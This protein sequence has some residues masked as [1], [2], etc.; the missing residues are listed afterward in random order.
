MRWHAAAALALVAM[1]ALAATRT[2]TPAAA[3][4]NRLTP[5]AAVLATAKPLRYT[6][7]GNRDGSRRFVFDGGLDD[8]RLFDAAKA[9]VPYLLL[10]TP[11]AEERWIGGEILWVTPTKASSGFELDLG[12]I[13]TIDR[14]RIDGIHAPFLKRARVEGSGDRAHWTL[15]AADTTL[16]DLPD[17]QLKNHD[18]TFPAGAHRYVRVT[19]DDR[20][21][22]RVIGMGDVRARV[23]T[24][25]I[26]AEGPRLN[27][28]FHARGSE[29]GKSRYRIVLPG[30]HLPIAAVQ[31]QVANGN[32]FR[33]ASISEGRLTNGAIEQ[34][35]LGNAKL[36]RAERDGAVAEQLAIPIEFPTGA[37]LELLVDDANNPPLQITGIV[38]Q[39]APL[40]S[41]YFESRDGAPLTA[42]Y[43]DDKR[44]APQYD[45]EASRHAAEKSVAPEAKWSP[46]PVTA[47]AES[48]AAA[49]PL[50]GAVV[51][52]NQFRYAR[53]IASS[54]PGLASLALD[55][56]VMAHSNALADLRI[57]DEHDA[58]VPYVVEVRADPLTVPLA[59]P[60]ARRDG[61]KSVYRLTLPFATLPAETK[62]VLTTSSRV[63]QRSVQLD[64]VREN[65][66]QTLDLETWSSAD[67]A[68]PAPPLLFC[69]NLSGISALDLVIDEGDNA[70]LAITSASLLVPA[71][72]LRFHRPAGPLRLLYGNRQVAAPRY[73]L[74]LL[75]PRLFSEAAT[76]LTLTSPVTAKE[77]ADEARSHTIFWI[78]IAGAV[79]VLLV[80]IARLVRGSESAP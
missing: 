79:V 61:S 73:D 20:A 68:T 34:V 75:A 62:L 64:A 7:E 43:G 18:V 27:A 25:T 57:V 10:A 48:D 17:E 33:D 71:R 2:V 37:E 70:P 42:T 67:P 32:V 65:H 59:L 45:L 77:P 69:C 58:Q 11:A 24:N 44:T 13:A 3:G 22:A 74:S 28:T 12:S 15:L 38:L 4:P 47:H 55:A 6:I 21:S 35:P 8:L 49:L 72:A 5:D 53:P 50:R 36:R 63:F 41:I 52:P 40:P 14:V 54:A 23:Q 19:W 78:A 80:V 46:A 30:A 26:A 1:N 9:E 66:N 76:E 31:L 29:P 51:D 39:L 56:E 60:A 16:F